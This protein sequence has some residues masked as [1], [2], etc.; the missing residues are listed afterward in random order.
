MLVGQGGTEVNIDVSH[1]GLETTR[2]IQLAIE[3]FDLTLPVITDGQLETPNIRVLAQQ[4]VSFAASGAKSRQK[5]FFS[6]S[7]LPSGVHHGQIRLLGGD[8]LNIDDVRHFTVTVE[9]AAEILIITADG[10]PTRFFTQAIAPESDRQ[11]GGPSPP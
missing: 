1:I 8:G 2:T 7:G 10:V 5:L 9:A 6:L 11:I 4:E 3:A